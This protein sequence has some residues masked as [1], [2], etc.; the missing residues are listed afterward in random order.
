MEERYIQ[1]DYLQK[2]VLIIGDGVSGNR[3]KDMLLQLDGHLDVDGPL[4]KCKEVRAALSQTP[5]YNLIYSSFTLEDGDVLDVFR[6]V[7]PRCFVAFYSPC[8]RAALQSVERLGVSCFVAPW[9]MPDFVQVLERMWMASASLLGT[10]VPTASMR[11]LDRV[12]VCKN[13]AS[14][15]LM[16]K[17]ISYFRCEGRKT[18]AVDCH[19]EEYLTYDT[20]GRLEA[21][22]NPDLFFRINRQY[23][24][25]VQSVKSILKIGGSRMRV[26]LRGCT[27]HL[28]YVSR[29]RCTSF[30]RWIGGR[31]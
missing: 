21:R 1:K 24:A 4:G 12:L 11:Y 18:Y 27:G 5:D 3:M 2:K 30:N 9:D 6:V 29:A 28:I 22:L 17:D 23:L 25:N 19:G 10:V 13:G 20:I 16:A 14:C 15:L 31:A 26:I 7:Q 8:D